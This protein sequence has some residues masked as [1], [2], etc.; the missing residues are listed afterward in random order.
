VSG[1]NVGPSLSSGDN[2]WIGITIKR[3]LGEKRRRLKKKSQ[4]H[5]AVLRAGYRQ[6]S[7][8]EGEFSSLLNQK[9]GGREGGKQVVKG[10]QL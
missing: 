10:I 7:E 3:D 5:M 6:K 8:N 9:D 4:T 1:A 2:G